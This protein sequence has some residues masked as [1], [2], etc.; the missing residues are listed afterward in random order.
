[1]ELALK[2][3]AAQLV[4]DRSP[5]A[6]RAERLRRRRK[7]LRADLDRVQRLYDGYTRVLTDEEIRRARRAARD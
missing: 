6:R 7:V 4:G 2:W 5:S 3:K 1:M